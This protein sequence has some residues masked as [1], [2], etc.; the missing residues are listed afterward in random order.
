MSYTV[1]FIG[2]PLPADDDELRDFMYSLEEAPE[3]EPLPAPFE[4]LY[5]TFA[6]KYPCI[7]DDQDSPWSGGP[8]YDDFQAPVTTLGI[9]Y[10]RVED[11]LPWLI[12]T[13]NAKGF[14]VYDGQDDVLYRPDGGSVSH[15]FADSEP[16]VEESKPWWRFW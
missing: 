10:S 1:D 12:A 3:G 6:A 4:D 15:V 8:L 14:A 2:V 13:A 5:R 11:V 16:D 9:V 7:I